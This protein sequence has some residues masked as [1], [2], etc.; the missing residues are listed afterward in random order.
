MLFI[1]E[2]RKSGACLGT[3]QSFLEVA[4]LE[5]KNNWIAWQGEGLSVMETI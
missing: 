4:D 5:F 1:G 3:E 2:M